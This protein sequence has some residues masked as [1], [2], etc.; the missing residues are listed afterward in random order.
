MFVHDHTGINV[1]MCRIT[2]VVDNFYDM[3]QGID[4]VLELGSQQGN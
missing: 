3:V 1:F 4:D 2:L